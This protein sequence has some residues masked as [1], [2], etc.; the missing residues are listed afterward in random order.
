MVREYTAWAGL[1]IACCALLACGEPSKSEGSAV[2]SA[3]PASFDAADLRDHE[4]RLRSQLK[5]DGLPGADVASGPDPYQLEPLP[6]GAAAGI[7]RGADQ[8][9]SFDAA[10]NELTGTLLRLE[11]SSRGD[12]KSVV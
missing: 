1:G 12:R 10:G 2:P 3:A 11:F 7:L 8:V 6:G 9:V 5:L 4:K